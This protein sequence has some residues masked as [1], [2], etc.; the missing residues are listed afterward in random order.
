MISSSYVARLRKSLEQ[1]NSSLTT[2]VH[3]KSGLQLF[4]ERV[5]H[6]VN[7]VNHMDSI[8]ENWVSD[9]WFGYKNG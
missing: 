4:A 6:F 9:R 8:T 3:L 7:G 5:L 1:V 2:F